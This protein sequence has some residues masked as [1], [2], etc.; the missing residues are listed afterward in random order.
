MSR[1]VLLGMAAVLAGACAPAAAGSGAA[2]GIPDEEQPT[3]L[4]SDGGVLRPMANGGRVAIPGGWATVTLSPL[5]LEREALDLDVA[6]TDVDGRP[7]SADLRVAYEM[8]GMDHGSGAERALAHA[9]AYRMPL[10]LAMPG[11][12]RLTVLIDRGGDV[13]TLVVVLPQAG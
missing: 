10:H 8:V 2:E 5:P 13:T 1:L 9:G 7:V 6:V 3:I 12:W 11:S 4:V